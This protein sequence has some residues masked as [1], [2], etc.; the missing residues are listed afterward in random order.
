MTRKVAWTAYQLG[1]NKRH[2][3]KL[4]GNFKAGLIKGDEIAEDFNGKQVVYRVLVVDS[5]RNIYGVN[6]SREIE[7]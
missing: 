1:R 5:E 6:Y 7:S 4:C 3:F 2:E